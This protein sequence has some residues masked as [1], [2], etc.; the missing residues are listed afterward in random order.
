[1]TKYSLSIIPDQETEE[2]TKSLCNCK[3]CTQINK[4]NKKW[5]SFIPKTNLQKRM[6]DVIYKIEKR[7]K[8][9]KKDNNKYKCLKV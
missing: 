7:E 5:K 8:K 9:K 3:N 2:F 4:S 1:M 6:K